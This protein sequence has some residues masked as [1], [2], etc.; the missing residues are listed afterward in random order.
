MSTPPEAERVGRARDLLT[1]V[2]Q[3]IRDVLARAVALQD[4][5]DVA[6]ARAAQVC[7]FVC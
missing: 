1:A 4:A 6:A 7:L 5:L 3:H 2:E